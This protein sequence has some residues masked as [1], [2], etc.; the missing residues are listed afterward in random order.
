MRRNQ[1]TTIAIAIAITVAITVTKTNNIFERDHLENG[2][3]SATSEMIEKHVGK[4]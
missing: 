4:E 3:L 2:A 1:K